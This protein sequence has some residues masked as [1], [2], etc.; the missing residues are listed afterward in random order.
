MNKFAHVRLFCAGLFLALAFSAML[1]VSAFADEGDPPP[2]EPAPPAVE[3][4]VPDTSSEEVPAV[5]ATEEAPVV[6]EPEAGESDVEADVAQDPVEEPIADTE[7]TASPDSPLTELPENTELVILGEMGEPV[8]L[9]SEEAAAILLEGDPMWCPAGVTPGGVGCTSPYATFAALLADPMF[10]GGGPAVNGV[11]WVRDNYN[12]A[13]NAAITF[14][15]A[16]LTTMRN[17]SLTIKGGWTGVGTTI[18]MAMPSA[19]DVPLNITGWL[20]DVT[21]SDLTFTGVSGTSVTVNTT[22]NI[23]LTNIHSSTSASRGADLD[24]SAGTGNVTVTSSS[25][26]QSS[27][28]TGLSIS[29]KGTVTL[30]SVTANNNFGDGTNINNSGAATDKN[31]T[32]TGS[33]FS[34][35]RNDGLDIQSWGLVTL[36]NISANENGAV[37][38]NGYG[39]KVTNTAS[40]TFQNV[41][42]TGTTI[43]L[44]NWSGNIEVLSSGMITA[45]N[46]YANSSQGGTGAYLNNTSS[47]TPKGV[48]LT[49]ASQ[50]KFNDLGGLWIE[51]NGVVTLSNITAN[52]N[53]GGSGAEIDNTNYPTGSFAVSLSGTN[54]FNNNWYYGLDVNSDGAITVSNVTANNNGQNMGFYSG[55]RLINSAAPTPQNV[56]VSGTNFF[57]GNNYYGLH[58]ESQGVISVNSITANDNVFSGAAGAYLHNNS[59]ADTSKKAVTLT[60]TNVMNGNGGTGLDVASYGPI[61]LNNVTAD[62]NSNGIDLHNLLAATPQSVTL[63]GYT[64]ANSNDFNG[65]RIISKGVIKINNLTAS[66]NGV[67]N[68]G[69]GADLSNNALGVVSSVTFTGTN[70]TNGNY[71]GGLKVATNGPITLNNLTASENEHGHGAEL[72]NQSTPAQTVK[73][74][75]TNVFN[76]NYSSGL[77][78][79]SFGAVTLNNVTANLNL[80]IALLT[81]YGVDIDNST[82]SVISSVTLTGTNTFSGNQLDNLMIKSRGAV[83]LNNVRSDSSVSQNGVTIENTAGGNGSQQP[84]TL[85]GSNSFKSN[86]KNGLKI[87]SFGLITTNSI[88]ASQNGDVSGYGVDLDNA[89]GADS[90]L[91]VKGITLNGVN[92]FDEN[93]SGG[94]NVLTLGPINTNNL[95]ATDSTGGFGV[96]LDNSSAPSPQATNVKGTNVFNSNQ[97]TGLIVK[98]KGAVTLN[99]ITAKS[100]MTGNGANIENTAGGNTA[101]QPVTINGT[102]TFNSNYN[103]GLIVTSYGL[104]TTNNI[105]ASENGL[106]P[107]SGYGAELTNDGASALLP[108]KGITMNGTNLFSTNNNT[109]LKAYSLGPIKVNNVTSSYSEDGRGAELNNG[110]APSDQGVTLTGSNFFWQNDGDGLNIYT[111]GAISLNSVNASQNGQGGT[112]NGATLNNFPSGG[113]AGVTFSG[114]NTFSENEDIGLKIDSKGVVSINSITAIANVNSHGVDINNTWSGVAKAVNLTGSN[115]T[116]GNNSNGLY[117]Q[118]V[119]VITVNNLTANG[120]GSYGA[121]LENFTSTLPQN[122]VLKGT[123]TFND[124][125]FDGLAVTTDGAVSSATSLTANGNDNNGVSISNTGGTNGGVSLLGTN[126]FNNN[127]DHGLSVHSVG[128]ITLNKVTASGNGADLAGPGTGVLLNNANAG[129]VNVT[130]TGVNVFNDNYISG[131][132][133]TSYGTINL[134]NITANNT[135]IGRGAI[136]SSLTAGKSVTLGGTN[137]FVNNGNDSNDSGLYISS[138]GAITINNLTASENSGNGADLIN[139]N[140]LSPVAY[141]VKLTGTTTLNNNGASGMELWASGAVTVNNVSANGNLAGGGMLID[142][143]FL[144]DPQAVTIA[145]INSFSYNSVI[146]LQVRSFGAVNLAKITADRNGSD[147]VFVDGASNAVTIACAVLT[148]NTTGTGLAIDTSGL[149]TLKGVLSSGNGGNY[150]HTNASVPDVISRTC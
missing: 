131:L 46:L 15:G 105:T 104:I 53:Q 93:R 75:G 51:T 5:D 38:M 23:V 55:A 13:D 63:N 111:K 142:N 33:E 40:S 42:F 91:P 39:V 41:V 62:S 141:A 49:G 7:T 95:T 88:T 148:G 86:E 17:F 96:R 82:G 129:E 48:T 98:S 119:G 144:V 81:G 117:V 122:V 116:S 31:V 1:P 101:P 107:N 124:N 32:V 145:G 35:N 127:E 143:D 12:G 43:A 50:F 121:V 3:A 135:A 16:S 54:V 59:G 4:D 83:I 11:I 9:A 65:L 132:D 87:A 47:P 64:V 22:K 120:N 109:G 21:L 72:N 73:L 138:M 18:N 125:T 69:Y 137:T 61:T 102:N 79:D 113:F 150:L 118:S 149:V 97:F 84:V 130:L 28:G 89:T 134:S 85:N 147:G 99:S 114:T 14:N 90:S 67:L 115:V 108:L 106:V 6:E 10:A 57:N 25:F 70:I 80:G 126:I 71:S 112:G 27:G 37:S 128:A 60:G 74:T 94:L 76:S 92:V 58:V 68:S 19:F 52:D 136:I 100:S 26:N 29:S 30:T 78:I 34:G 8:P 66:F 110:S 140:V 77:V 44:Q 139:Q 36:N 2:T 20:G 146:G 133:V 24:N 123:N 103:T 56:T 45:S